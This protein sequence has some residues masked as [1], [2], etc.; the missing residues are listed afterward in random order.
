MS[1]VFV[2][3][4][5]PD[6]DAPNSLVNRL[7]TDLREEGIKVWLAPDDVAPGK[8]YGTVI[9]EAIRNSEA[10]LFLMSAHLKSTPN[11]AR[12][13]QTAREQGKLV[14]PVVIGRAADDTLYGFLRGMQRYDLTMHYDAALE[15]L[16]A[17][18][19][20]SVRQA[21]PVPPHAPR[22]KGYIFISY[23]EE[24]SEFV[25]ML[26]AY[27][28]EKGFGFW[29]YQVS[30]RNMHTQLFEELEGVLRGASA[31]V[32]VLSPDWKRSRWTTREYLFAE[33]IDL[34]RFLIMIR[35]MEPTLVT[36]GLP[37]IDFMRDLDRGFA[38]LD[39]EL[40]AKGLG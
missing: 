36:Q 38:R 1:C 6:R 16:L 25:A 14:L 37:Y 12:E 29:D 8:D 39:A 11:M 5:P 19:P 4:S 34:P 17:A 13:L 33:A 20:D 24:D 28:K 32:S 10:V 3:Y 9:P 15:G 21:T 35:E 22:S 7:L 23:A 30:D 40:R 2:S 18:L 27:L 31:L 26:R